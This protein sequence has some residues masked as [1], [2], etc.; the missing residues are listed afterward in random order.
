MFAFGFKKI[1]I[2][3]LCTQDGLNDIHTMENS[4]AAF[5]MKPLQALKYSFTSRSKPQNYDTHQ[6]RVLLL[7]IHYLKNYRDARLSDSVS[8]SQVRQNYPVKSR[9]LQNK[10]VFIHLLLL[11]ISV[12]MTSG[13]GLHDFVL[14][15]LSKKFA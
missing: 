5:P 13:V 6:Q 4:L 14:S 15:R 7:Q 11:K 1:N 8:V 2:L 12:S 10:H 3:F 9:L